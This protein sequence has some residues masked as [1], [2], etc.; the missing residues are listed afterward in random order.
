[1]YDEFIFQSLLEIFGNDLENFKETIIKQFPNITMKM[2]EEYKIDKLIINLEKPKRTI[3]QV[4]PSKSC[5]CK[6]RTWGGEASVY[7]DKKKG[8]WNYGEQCKKKAIFKKKYCAIHLKQTLRPEGLSHGSINEDPPHD[9]YLKYKRKYS[10][11]HNI[12]E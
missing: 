9:H 11:L 2:L 4:I 10:I 5:R 6:A 1:M 12:V 7:Y 3:K 8:K